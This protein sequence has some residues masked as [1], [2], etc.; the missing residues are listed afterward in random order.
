VNETSECFS[1]ERLLVWQKAVEFTGTVYTVTKAFPKEEVFAQ[2]SQ[3]RRASVSVAANIAEGTS[4]SASRD[5][6]RSFEI[7][8]GPLSKTAT[9]FQTAASQGFVTQQIRGQA[10]S[11]IADV[12]MMLSGLR[13]SLNTKSD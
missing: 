7:A 2:T 11:E 12:S 5:R 9:L 4:R 6:T 10:R 1:Y 3:L 8:Y 13:R